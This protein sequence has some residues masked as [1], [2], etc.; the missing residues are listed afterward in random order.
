[1]ARRPP[2]G[3]A[4][5][6][7]TA[8]RQRVPA[9]ERRQQACTRRVVMRR[10]RGT[11]CCSATGRDRRSHSP[12]RRLSDRFRGWHHAWRGV[13]RRFS[14]SRTLRVRPT[15]RSIAL[16]HRRLSFRVRRRAPS[17][18]RVPLATAR[19][20]IFDRA[21]NGS[22]G[23]RA[24]TSRK[25]Y[26]FTRLVARARVRRWMCKRRVSAFAWQACVYMQQA[27]AR[28]SREL[29]CMTSR[30]HRY[31]TRTRPCPTCLGAC[32]GRHKELTP[33]DKA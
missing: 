14:I 15:S 2:I 12:Q 9:R 16:H 7:R 33:T 5:S 26:A 11:F 22:T 1:M 18:R 13:M 24:M 3:N 21:V 19:R 23:Q 28:T 10:T 6:R 29:L 27:F 4:A 32:P 31:A 30:E 17:G 25:E 8:A 20:T